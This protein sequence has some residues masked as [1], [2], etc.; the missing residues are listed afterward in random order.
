MQSELRDSAL[1]VALTRAPCN[2]IGLETLTDFETLRAALAQTITSAPRKIGSLVWHSKLDTGFSAG[3][4]LRALYQ[5]LV[6]RDP[7]GRKPET[8]TEEVR[9]FIDRIHAVFDAF[10]QL[11]IPTIAVLHGVV[12]GGGFEL[13]LTADVR[14]AEKSAR[15]C[16]PE[17]RLGLVPGFGGIP[18]LRRDV[19]NGAIRD[20][21]FTG[22]SLRAS[23]AHAMGLVQHLVANGQGLAAAT[24][25]AG[26]M[27]RFDAQVVAQAKAFAKPLPRKE[28]DQEK[29]LFVEMF[30]APTVRAALRA[31]V[32]SDDI[33][34]Y[35]PGSQ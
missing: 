29:K 5:G 10:D 23:S 11:P 21:L 30:S 22:R 33:R 14:I 7:E 28:L 19:G 12:F 20:L 2:E 26:Q 4:D 35:L 6:T 32:E 3:A 34:P 15:F 8:A 13:A 24:Q 25:M 1:F 27:A 31:F 17:L 9:S 16:F 18:R